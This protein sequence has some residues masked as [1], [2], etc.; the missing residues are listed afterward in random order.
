MALYADETLR[1]DIGG[2]LGPQFASTGTRHSLTV[3]QR[4]PP[5]TVIKALRREVGFACP[6]C[7]CPFLTWHHF[8]PPWRTKKH[9]NPKGMIALCPE[10]AS[11]ADGGHWSID[12]LRGLKRPIAKENR[13]V[14]SWPWK[15][16]RAVFMLGN[17]YYVGERPLL[18][19]DGRSVFAASKYCPPGL[20]SA[21]VVFSVDLRD[22]VGHT[23]LSLKNNFL[24][25][26]ASDFVDVNC[27]PQAKVF[28]AFSASEDI[29]LRLSHRRLSLSDFLAQVPPASFNH[30]DTVETV[31]ALMKATA[32]DSDGMIPVI[33][34]AGRLKTKSLDMNLSSATFSILFKCYNNELVKVPGRFFAP[35]LSKGAIVF[36]TREREIMRFG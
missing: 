8:D 15:P 27:P 25:F 26:Y 29:A 18:S 36:Q 9:H 28:E 16:E 17:S 30:Y 22:Q 24:S 12:Q 11:H 35:E 19:L 32:I 34:I 23:I 20:G 4:T 33:G 1:L 31:S 21:E 6:V 3:M 14:A 10:H 5:N 13:I 7:G 2:C